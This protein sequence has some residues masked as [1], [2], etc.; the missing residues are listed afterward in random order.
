VVITKFWDLDVR[1][2]AHK[3]TLLNYGVTGRFPQTEIYALTSQLRRAVISI[4]SCTAEGFCRYHYR[5]RLTFYYDA[6][7][8]IGEVQS[9]IIDAKDLGYI[10]DKAYQQVFDQT[11]RVGVILGG[12]IRNTE[13]L[14]KSKI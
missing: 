1:Q 4:E 3:L 5:D 10:D 8:S 7:G 14:V 9:Q 13:K 6:R 2:E 11:E 12:L